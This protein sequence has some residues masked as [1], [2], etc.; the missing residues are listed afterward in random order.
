MKKRNFI[1]AFPQEEKFLSAFPT[2]KHLIFNKWFPEDCKVHPELDDTI[3]FTYRYCLDDASLTKLLRPDLHLKIFA[4]DSRI[5]ISFKDSPIRI[6]SS[7]KLTPDDAKK[8]FSELNSPKKITELSQ[9]LISLNELLTSNK[10]SVDNSDDPFV[11]VTFNSPFLVL[12][13]P[14]TDILS[15]K[16]I[17][18]NYKISAKDDQLIL[19]IFFR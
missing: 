13:K 1:T 9:T 18:S 15:N 12:N 7:S 14:L 8:Y 2:F 5:L 11:T 19:K 17:L 10:I 6:N 3:Q 4:A 16:K